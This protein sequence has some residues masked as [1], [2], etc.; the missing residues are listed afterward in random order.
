MSQP[1]PTPAKKESKQVRK[2][3]VLLIED[4]KPIRRF[5][6]PYLETKDFKVIEAVT[7]QEG[8]SLASS[9]KP[10]LIL[11]DLGLPD[12]DGLEVLQRLREW[13]KTPVIILSARG[14]DK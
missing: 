10:D 9:H 11:L 6:K 8:L 14:R 4:E 5:I 7:G 2:H 13:T 12:M 1:I 3:L